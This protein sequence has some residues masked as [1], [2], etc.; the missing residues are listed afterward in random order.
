MLSAKNAARCPGLSTSPAADDALIDAVVE[1]LRSRTTVDFSIY[2]PAMLQRRIAN[3]LASTGVG[4]AAEY[5][6]LLR[7]SAAEPFRLLERITIKVSRFYRYALA[8]DHLRDVVL[9]AWHGPGAANRCASGAPDAGP[10]K[11]PTL[12]RSTATPGQRALRSLPGPGAASRSPR[13][14]SS[15]ASA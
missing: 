7:A 5:L 15:R 13:S 9:P 11:S 14:C 3:H 1:I 8:F 6:S 2:R 10:V 12:S 4:S